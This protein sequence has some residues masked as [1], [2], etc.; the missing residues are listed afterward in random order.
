[1][2][3]PR[4]SPGMTGIRL[5]ELNEA[6]K[7]Q[8]VDALGSVYEESPWVARDSWSERPFRSIEELRTAMRETVEAASEE[9]RL[10]LLRAHPDLGERTEMTDASKAEQSSAGLDE[11]SPAQYET[12]QR[13]ND[14]YR[15]E[16]GFPFI[17]AVK[18]ATPDGIQAA[19]ERRVEN[20]ESEEFRTAL[21]EVHEIARLRLD[22]LL[23]EAS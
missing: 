3:P 8:F 11:L 21:D 20:S 2:R 10:A 12:F 7:D 22:D 17:M 19:M 9:R 13:L 18:D 1:V 6:G 14:R 15:D 16:F 4:R 5:A 23:V